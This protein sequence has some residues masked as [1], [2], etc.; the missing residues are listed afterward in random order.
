MTKVDL[1]YQLQAPL[2]AQQLARLAELRG[3]YGVLDLRLDEAGGTLQ[4]EY[5]ASR[6]D[7]NEVTATLHRAGIPALRA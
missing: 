5:D 2:N 3:V 1:R 6:L 4:V 7:P